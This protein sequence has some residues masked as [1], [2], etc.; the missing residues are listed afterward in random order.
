N[1]SQKNQISI[2]ANGLRINEFNF[3]N[4]LISFPIRAEVSTTVKITV[5]NAGGSAVDETIIR[6]LPPIVPPT[7]NITS[8]TQ[9]PFETTNCGVN[10]QAQT[11]NITQ[12]SQILVTVNGQTLNN[13]NFNP[14][15]QRITFSTTAGENTPIKIT[16]TNAAGNASDEILIRCRPLPTVSI[17]NPAQNPLVT[18]NCEV[19]VEAQTQNIELREQISILIN[20]QSF[21][22]FNFANGKISFSVKADENT[23]VKITVNNNG[24]SASDE[25][26]IR[27]VPPIL[28]PTV[29]ISNPSQ[30]P[31]ETTDC[32]LTV[33][34]Q[35][36]NV[37]QKNQ[38]SISVN[39][40]PVNDFNFN[41][42]QVSWQVRANE[43]TTVRIT[44]TNS[45]GSNSDETVIRCLPPVVP[46]TIRITEPTQ[47]PFETT[48]C[49]IKFRAQVENITQRNQ[50]LVTINGQ[51]FNAYGFNA[52]NGLINFPV[53][54][55]A[56]TTIKVSVTNSAGTASDEITIRCTPPP[57]V[58]ITNPSQNPWQ[59]TDCDLTIQAQTTYVGE[60]NQISIIAN[61][62]A[63]N[64]FDFNNGNI[65]FAVKADENTNIK[66]TVTNA[67]GSASDETLIKC[68]PPEEKKITICHYPPG[69]TANPQ[70][71][72]IPESAWAA[73][74]A[75]GDVMGPCPEIGKPTVVITKTSQTHVNTA[76]C[77]VNVEARAEHVWRKSQIK[78]FIDGNELREFSFTR[79]TGRIAFKLQADDSTMLRIMLVNSVGESSDDIEIKCDK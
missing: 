42:N 25:T 23:P 59:T 79:A 68:T 17:T 7:I 75:H 49:E 3:E 57:T 73:H 76:E 2:T 54:A 53:K 35:V 20:G 31:L 29:R 45:A 43:N 77:E 41:N 62:R 1:I 78:I 38:I 37:E 12:K 9:N 67:G 34:A 56:S 19:N 44:V 27:C 32:E 15:N 66:I 11:Q 28:P 18:T 21:A 4:N 40:S 33:Q 22:N 14:A 69:N 26:L 72:E 10:V 47:N 65:S 61:G 8:P 51:R 74:Q 46:P 60:R 71:I 58:K 39:G 36:A 24:G 64:N 55:E 52:S 13:F 6:C 48:N 16:V 5:S 63:V 70:T 50:I 30:N